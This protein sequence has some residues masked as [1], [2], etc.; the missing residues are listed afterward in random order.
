[1]PLQLR[2]LL[3]LLLATVFNI[4]AWGQS[5][6]HLHHYSYNIN[7]GLLHSQVTSAAY[8]GNGFLW[9]S[10]GNGL[11]KFDG[12]NFSQVPVSVGSKGIPDD[13]YVTLFP[14]RN[15]NLL[16]AHS[17]GISEYNINSDRFTHYTMTGNDRQKVWLLMEEQGN[18]IWSLSLP[19]SFYLL[20]KHKMIV[21][22]SI[23]FPKQAKVWKA[24]MVKSG[25]Q[26]NYFIG[27][28]DTMIYILNKRFPACLSYSP[29]KLQ[30][31]FFDIV[32]YRPDSLLVASE[33]GIE[34]MSIS[35]GKFELVCRYVFTEKK[36]LTS[37][38]IRMHRLPSG[39]YLVSEGNKVY[40]LNIDEKKYVAKLVD[41]QGQHFLSRGLVTGFFTDRYENCWIRTMNEGLHKINY[42]PGFK[43]YGTPDKRKNFVKTIYADKQNNIVLC[44]TMGSG[45]LVF[46]TA[47]QLLKEIGYFSGLPSPN[48]VSAIYKIADH[49]FLFFMTGNWHVYKLNTRSF[50]LDRVNV[51][52]N[53][54]HPAFVADY[55]MTL[56]RA[57]NTEII[58]QNS[59]FVYRLRWQAPLTLHFE[60]GTELPTAS[61][62][63]FRDGRN[64]LWVG[65]RWKYF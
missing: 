39:N 65:G 4:T 5:L 57:G 21:K 48:T 33:R 19:G 3:P 13:K 23:F 8:D 46:D 64:R 30:H 26:D 49:E 51:D 50:K 34:K 15:G 14:L 36:D 35:S 20:D 61:I 43:Y 59:F 55:H 28:N 9:I 1:M 53:K 45:L 11:Q 17:K 63:S 44:G 29:G 2:S 12:N 32:E 41:M 27:F 31:R 22:D 58:M 38:Y 47:R 6:K 42:G 24:F 7:E 10:T 40:E 54:V 60:S 18:D 16:L 25:K 56:H 52:T 37:E 62:G